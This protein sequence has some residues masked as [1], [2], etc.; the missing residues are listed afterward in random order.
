VSFA[1]GDQV[2]SAS[3]RVTVEGQV[4]M[5]SVATNGQ[6]FATVVELPAHV[7]DGNSTS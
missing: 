6:N 4:A 7:T 2:Y 5:T 1:C 3:H